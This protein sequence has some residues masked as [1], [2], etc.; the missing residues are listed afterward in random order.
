MLKS[1]VFFF[2]D[3]PFV[4]FLYMMYTGAKANLINVHVH[5]IYMIYC[6]I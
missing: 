4:H 6:I 3:H 1:L 2:I 5:W